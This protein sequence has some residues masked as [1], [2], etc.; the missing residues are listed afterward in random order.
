MMPQKRLPSLH[1]R[2]RTRRSQLGLTGAELAQRAGI[3]PSYV[4]LIENGAKV[5][6]EGVAAG[7]ARALDDDEALYRAWA[8]AARLG[9][10]DLDLLNQIE[11]ISR[12]PA[13]M[14][15]VESGEELP[16]LEP[17]AAGSPPREGA[18]DLAARVR[19][20]ASRLAS[21]LAT[22]EP[23]REALPPARPPLEPSALPPTEPLE[24]G[25]VL[26]IPILSPGADPDRLTTT[27]SPAIRDRVLV[28]PRLVAGHEPER[29]FAYEVTAPAMKHLRG[30]AAP[31]DLVVLGRGG[32]VAPNRICAVRTS[33]GL[34]LARVLLKDRSLL[35]LPGEGEHDFESIEV[36]DTAALREAIAGTQVLL[37]RR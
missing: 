11:E 21:P 28:D 27:P 17:P 20:V 30:V 10:H 26:R 34:V 3:S 37:I 16:K 22:Q 31:G 25:A 19:E 7:L 32:A 1:A 5:P 4:S 29:L 15:L 12:T 36:R 2:M 24:A 23:G 18:T 6:D 8:R 13:Y 33:N 14:D 35:L 9:L